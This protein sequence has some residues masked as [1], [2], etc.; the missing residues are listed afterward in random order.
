MPL[1]LDL[2]VEDVTE[3]AWKEL[4]H[5]FLPDFQPTDHN[6]AGSSCSTAPCTGTGG[7]AGLGGCSCGCGSHLNPE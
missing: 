5:Q 2:D 1:D 3:E 7:C 4:V 6:S